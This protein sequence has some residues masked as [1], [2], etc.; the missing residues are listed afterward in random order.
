MC[1]IFFLFVDLC[2]LLFFFFFFQA[3]DGIRDKLVTGVQT[4]ALPIMVM[5]GML[6][7]RIKRSP[8]AHARIVGIDTAKAAALPGVKAV[9]TRADFPDI[10]LERAHIGTMP[11]NLRDLSRNCMAG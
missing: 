8:Y 7:G 4:C 9:I 5:P 3:E 11:H 10:T 6:W 1:L 2:L